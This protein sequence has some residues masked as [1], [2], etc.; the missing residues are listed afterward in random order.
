MVTAT[1]GGHDFH[2]G[3]YPASNCVG[4]APRRQFDGGSNPVG[5]RHLVVQ[6]TSIRV[7]E[8]F[9]TCALGRLGGEE[10]IRQQLPDYIL[11]CPPLRRQK[12][13]PVV[14]LALVEQFRERVD[15]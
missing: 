2:T 6:R 5:A 4:N 11:V 7:T 10:W 8:A 12:P 13:V 1:A 15:H 9:P 14:R 3:R